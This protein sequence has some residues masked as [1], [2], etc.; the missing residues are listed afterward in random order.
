LSHR[1][2]NGFETFDAEPYMTPKWIRDF[3]ALEVDIKIQG[4]R[5]AGAGGPLQCRSGRRNPWKMSCTDAGA[6]LLADIAYPES[7]QPLPVIIS[8]HGGRWK[9]GNKRDASSID[10]REW[11]GFGFFAMSID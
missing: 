2:G 4:R 10:V 3:I 8:V 5:A 7:K 11:A 6:G 9:G 1:S